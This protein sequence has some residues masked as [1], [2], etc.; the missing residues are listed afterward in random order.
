[1]LRWLDKELSGHDFIAGAAYSMADIIA[2]TTLDFAEFTGLE[3][4]A[5][6]ANVEAWHKRVSARASASA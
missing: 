4:P 3:R 5:E 2:L 1:V 6:C